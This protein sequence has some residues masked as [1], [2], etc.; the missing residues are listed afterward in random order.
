MADPLRSGRRS[1]PADQL[2]LS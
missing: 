1:K 2:A